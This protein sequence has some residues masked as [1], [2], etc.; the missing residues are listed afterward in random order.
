MSLWGFIAEASR[1]LWRP[2][3]GFHGC[4]SRTPLTYMIR[5]EGKG[6]G[7]PKSRGSRREQE[8]L[9][10]VNPANA[11]SI[12]PV[13][14]GVSAGSLIRNAESAGGRPIVKTYYTT[15]LVVGIPPDHLSP[16]NWSGIGF[17]PWSSSPGKR[18]R[19]RTDA[20]LAA[21]FACVGRA[22][23]AA[24]SALSCCSRSLLLLLCSQERPP[25]HVSSE[26]VPQ[27]PSCCLPKSPNL[28]NAS[29][30][31][32]YLQMQRTPVG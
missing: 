1:S 16:W 25:A 7:S 15:S 13:V 32:D 21:A 10:P 12:R 22:E 27:L 4:R 6:K 20:W 30:A 31:W 17:F 8:R 9:R 29:G 26:C 23:Y 14:C 3:C 19:H 18:V 5:R 11:L 2:G 24:R 28:P